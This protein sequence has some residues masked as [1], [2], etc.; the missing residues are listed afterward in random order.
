[1][2]LTDEQ[3][4]Y[5]PD[6][7]LYGIAR[8]LSTHAQLFDHYFDTYALD[9]IRLI[10][11]MTEQD[12]EDEQSM[13]NPSLRVLGVRS[14]GYV[15][16]GRIDDQ[17]YRNRFLLDF[18]P[19]GS[20]LL[21]AV[22]DQGGSIRAAC[23]LDSR[24]SHA[25]TYA[26]EIW[27]GGVVLGVV[28]YWDMVQFHRLDRDNAIEQFFVWRR[29]GDRYR[30]RQLE[31]RLWNPYVHVLFEGPVKEKANICARPGLLRDRPDVRA[32]EEGTYQSFYRMRRTP[33]RVEVMRRYYS[34]YYKGENA[35]LDEGPR[36]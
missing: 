22:G 25:E 16:G 31:I 32:Y 33:S 30:G 3:R 8:W 10:E 14:N 29:I 11:E 4:Q 23:V 17:N 2:F 20:E 15:F 24:H 18:R 27:R 7:T 12:P 6:A 28:R 5:G 36:D 9:S 35:E 13:R 1:M 34:V 21:T 26:I 19:H